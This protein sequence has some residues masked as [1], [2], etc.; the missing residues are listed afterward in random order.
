MGACPLVRSPSGGLLEGRVGPEAGWPQTWAG[1]RVI[2]ARG[3]ASPRTTSCP[4]ARHRTSRSLFPA[5]WNKLTR[6]MAGA[7]QVG[8]MLRRRVSD[9]GPEAHG[10]PLSRPRREGQS[11]RRGQRGL[12]EQTGLWGGVE[13]Q[14]GL[15]WAEMGEGCRGGR[16]ALL[17][18]RCPPPMGLCLL[19]V[20]AGLEPCGG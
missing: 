3:P 11:G 15:P 5:Q 13:G 9:A 7:S 12:Q 8:Q 17:G 6:P 16:C 1:V 10:Q 18:A 14:A 19:V 2:W 20:R 4:W